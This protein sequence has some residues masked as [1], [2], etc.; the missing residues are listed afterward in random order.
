M[1]GVRH[2]TKR[3]KP[4]HKEVMSGTARAET[5]RSD[6]SE[7]MPGAEQGRTIGSDHVS[8]SC[9]PVEG[10]MSNTRRDEGVMSD[11]V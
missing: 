2:S 3:H 5:Q 10:V 9:D 7:V 1:S 11:T 4:G 6:V 8:Q